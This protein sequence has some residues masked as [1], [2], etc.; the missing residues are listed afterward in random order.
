MWRVERRERIYMCVVSVAIGKKCDS[1]EGKKRSWNLLLLA[2]NKRLFYA[3][4]INNENRELYL[5]ILS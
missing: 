3:H 4:Q 1:I 5:K 2:K